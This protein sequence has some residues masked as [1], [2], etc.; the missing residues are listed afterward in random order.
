MTTPGTS[1]QELVSPQPS[2]KPRPEYPRP[3]FVRAEWMSLNGWWKFRIDDQIVGLDERWFSSTDYPAEILVP[4]SLETRLSG[5]G[6]RSFH[7]CV[8]YQRDFQ[9]PKEWAGR[10]VRLNFGAVDYRATVWVNGIVVGWHEGGHTPFSCDIT[11]ALR[12]GSNIVAVRAEDPPTDRYIPRGKQHWEASPVNIFYARTTGIWQSV[13]LEPVHASHLES[14][15]ITANM[16][17]VVSVSVKIACPA[18]SQF[19][20]MTIQ[21]GGRTLASAMSLADGPRARISAQLAEPV[22]WSPD[23]PHLYDLKLELHS[24][25][26]RLDSV[27]SYFGVRSIA[28]QEGKVLLN[29]NPIYLKTVLDQGYWPDSNLTAPSD[30]AIRQDIRQVKELGFNGVRKHQKVEDP[31][32]LYWA[33]VMGLLV[34]AEMA[35][36]YLFDDDAVTR[37]TREWIE[38]VSRDYNH[39]CIIIWTP[40]NESWGVPN[41]SD[42][43][44]QA[45]LKALYYLTKSLDGTRLVIDNDGWEH[46]EVTDLFAIHDYT[47][48]G[49]EF[50]SRYQGAAQGPPLPLYGKLYLA[51]GQHYN[52]SPILLWEFGG[53][54]YVLPEDIARVPDNSWGYSG[55]EHDSE[56]ALSRIAGLYEAIARIPQIS[57]ICYT[58]LYDVEQEVNGLMTY[59][60]RLKFDPK[61]IREINSLLV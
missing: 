55:V 34:A 45:H 4:F 8:W 46:T 14:T 29:G 1:P 28:T 49:K 3:Q 41:L 36:A 23:Q 56:A 38:V 5:I 32:F 44:Q 40:V 54:G 19:V 53:V 43:R 37:M 31:R 61:A 13:W 48:T 2:L 26:G 24:P 60:R 6:D 47:R 17:G 39:P 16:D 9:V 11:G 22:L 51:P 50:L 58:Q 42:P 12:D 25:D 33:D 15:H 20:T 18:P 7:P 35:N 30:E 21:S 52:G 57:G 27:D 10:Q 59:D